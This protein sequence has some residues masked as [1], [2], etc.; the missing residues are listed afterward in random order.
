M[1]LE[2]ALTARDNAVHGSEERARLTAFVL[3]LERRWYSLWRR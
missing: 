1:D 3:A 2:K